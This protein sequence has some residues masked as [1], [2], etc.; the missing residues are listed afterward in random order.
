M[1][2]K[3]RPLLRNRFERFVALCMDHSGLANPDYET[4]RESVSYLAGERLRGSMIE[5]L[6]HRLAGNF[7]RLKNHHVVRPWTRQDL[8][9]WVPVQAIAVHRVAHDKWGIAARLTLK[10]MAGSPAPIIVRQQW[11]YKRCRAVSRDLGFR[12]YGRGKFDPPPYPFSA[13]EELT[14]LRWE[15]LVDPDASETEPCLTMLRT[16]PALQQ[17]NKTILK[18]RKREGFECMADH[19]ADFPC[20]ECALGYLTCPAGTHRNTWK[21]R[22]CPECD[23]EQAFWDADL[24]T[25]SCL[26]C[27]YRSLH[28]K[29]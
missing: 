8:F 11:S 29:K 12:Q 20:H 18:M 28:R 10:I 7:L 13:P 19:A 17:W 21:V 3:N 9:E 26:S 5:T 23:E 27:Y 22:Y 6:A 2:L 25:A 14:S 1:P 24:S 16:R 4:F 15:M